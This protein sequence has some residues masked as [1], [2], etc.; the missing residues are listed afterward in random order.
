VLDIVKRKD[1]K[2][3]WDA[4]ENLDV[5]CEACH[6]SYWYPGETTEYYRRLDRR[7]QE[8]RDSQPSTPAK[9]KSR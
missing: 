7:L 5:A 3:L 1:V 2:E 6:R 8:H 9:P 4:G